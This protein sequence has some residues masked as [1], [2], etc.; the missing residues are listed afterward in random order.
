MTRD[1]GCFGCSDLA[2]QP[3]G[4]HSRS[5]LFPRMR[6][7]RHVSVKG[8]QPALEMPPCCPL[9]TDKRVR[10]VQAPRRMGSSEPLTGGSA[11]HQTSTEPPSYCWRV[12]HRL[13]DNICFYNS[14]YKINS[15]PIC[16]P[17]NAPAMFS[18]RFWGKLRA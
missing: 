2:S 8:K 9:E 18:G 11:Y 17:S 14:P 13:E 10:V 5:P 3:P 12:C 1:R 4:F 6:A 7:I 16:Q 15:F